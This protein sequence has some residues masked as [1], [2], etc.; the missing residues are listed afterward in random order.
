MAAP[1]CG[2]DDLPEPGVHTIATFFTRTVALYLMRAKH[3]KVTDF[4]PRSRLDGEIEVRDD[5]P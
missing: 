5:N 3:S 1:G 4:E 2:G